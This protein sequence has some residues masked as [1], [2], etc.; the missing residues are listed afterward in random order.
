[1]VSDSGDHAGGRWQVERVARQRSTRHA[2]P[3]SPSSPRLIS[4]LLMPRCWRRFRLPTS[5][6]A[7]P[8]G[9]DSIEA[10]FAC[11]SQPR[12]RAK[13]R[14]RRGYPACQ[15]SEQPHAATIL[16]NR[17]SNLSPQLSRKV[18]KCLKGF[19]IVLGHPDRA[20]NRFTDRIEPKGP[21]DPSDAMV[22][23]EAVAEPAS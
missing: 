5:G 10:A 8:T 4:P 23:L 17:R 14:E 13:G 9:A 6:A 19:A 7:G 22:W 11:N 1:M 3:R 16:S 20:K 15:T 18:C 2:T 12:G 21:P